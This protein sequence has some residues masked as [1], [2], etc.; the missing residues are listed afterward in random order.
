MEVKA[1]ERG[2]IVVW[3]S[4]ALLVSL[5]IFAIGYLMW[6]TRLS[7]DIAM[8]NMVNIENG[9]YT[10]IFANFDTSII[11][12]LLGTF[13][14]AFPIIANAQLKKKAK[15]NNYEY[16]EQYMDK[17]MQDPEIRP[18]AAQ[19]FQTFINTENL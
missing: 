18:Y 12:A 3:I 2:Y 16:L 11:I 5:D 7:Y 8:Q 9:L 4:F 17:W 6:I 14:I 1:K 10:T 19:I 15:N 13:N